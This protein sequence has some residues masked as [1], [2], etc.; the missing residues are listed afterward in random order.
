MDVTF[1]T[2]F[3][4]KRFARDIKKAL[5]F[6]GYA[7]A[8]WCLLASWPA[9]MF[10][11]WLEGWPKDKE[12]LILLPLFGIGLM[13][14]CRHA[15]VRTYVCQMKQMFGGDT[16]VTCHITDTGYETV[17]GDLM[18]KMPW[19]KVATHY[20]FIDDDTVSLLLKRALPVLLLSELREHGIERN[21]LEVAFIKAGLQPAGKSKKRKLRIAISA[22]IGAVVVLCAFL[23]DCSAVIAYRNGL[24]CQ[25]TQIRLFDLI[26]GK[27]DPRRPVPPDMLRTKVVQLLTGEQAPN[28]FAYAFDPEDEDDKVGL[29]ARYGDW[30][31]VAY[32]P[33]GC[34]GWRTRDYWDAMHTNHPSTVYFGPQKEEWLKKIRPLASK[35]YESDAE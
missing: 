19:Q 25:D 14:L 5:T 20:H 18:Q 21:E 33:C 30:C 23:M 15:A 35:L 9:F 31:C 8:F 34:T 29:F 17:C 26:H 28:D 13:W 7:L 6:K 27:E 10:A 12:H 32:Y 2:R 22:L 3:N 1:S 16:P 24:R 11:S 4:A